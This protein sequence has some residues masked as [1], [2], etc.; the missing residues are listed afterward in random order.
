MKCV[1]LANGEYGDDLTPYSQVLKEADI[2][3]CAD[4]GANYAYALSVRPHCIIGDMDSINN[5]VREYFL[6]LDVPVKKYPRQKDFTDTQLALSEAEALGANEIILVG[7]LGK[8]LDHTLSNLYS[9]ME[10][11]QRG[12]KVSHLAAG[13]AVYLMSGELEITGKTGDLVSVLVLTDQ[14]LGVCER[15]FEYPLDRA[16]LSKGNPYTVSNRM[17]D[18]KGI[19][20]VEQGVLAVFHYFDH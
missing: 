17:L 14:A 20:T 9:C 12:I 6:G 4:G 2:V 16:V 11:V 1:I 3:L 8:R 15:G 7:S 10:L 5:R 13:M 19:I 18:E